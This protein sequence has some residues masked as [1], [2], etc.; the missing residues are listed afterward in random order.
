MDFYLI[1]ISIDRSSGEVGISVR[2]AEGPGRSSGGGGAPGRHEMGT[3]GLGRAGDGAGARRGPQERKGGGPPSLGCVEPHGSSWWYR[4]DGTQGVIAAGS[5]WPGHGD[6]VEQNGSRNRSCNSRRKKGSTSEPHRSP[7]RHH[8]RTPGSAQGVTGHRAPCTWCLRFHRTCG[9]GGFTDQ[10]G[11]VPQSF[12]L[13]G[14]GKLVLTWWLPGGSEIDQGGHTRCKIHQTKIQ[15]CFTLG[16]G[17]GAA[18]GPRKAP[19]ILRTGSLWGSRC[20]SR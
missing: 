16:W 8:G 6:P 10:K 4:S 7:R 14:R 17:W 5:W 2:K 3:W 9:P 1:S 11:V 18:R 19:R 12:P 20:R 13:Q 15:R